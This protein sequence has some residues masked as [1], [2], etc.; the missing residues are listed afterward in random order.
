MENKKENKK[1]NATERKS[2]GLRTP[3]K[4][5]YTTN[6]SR[7]GITRNKSYIGERI[8]DTVYKLIYEKEQIKQQAQLHYQERHEGVQAG[9][10]I[11]TDKWDIAA[12]V[13]AKSAKTAITN[14]K[15]I[16]VKRPTEG[17]NPNTSET[18][19]APTPTT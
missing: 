14:A 8:E 15:G 16:P 6:V 4:S 10:N 3:V 13:M 1:N 7:T 19:Q 9:A 11:R 12:E 2:R 18:V 5:A 17:E